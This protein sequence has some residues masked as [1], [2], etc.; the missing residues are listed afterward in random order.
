MKFD[1]MDHTGHSTE[2][3]D[4]ANPQQLAAAQARFD[5]LIAEGRTAAVRTG[6]AQSRIVRKFDPN[7][8]EVLF[9]PRLMGG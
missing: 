5:E 2:A 6:P 9:I 8:E 7:A 1:V 4:K 3:F